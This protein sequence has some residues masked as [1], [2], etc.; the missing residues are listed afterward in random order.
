MNK[1]QLARILID[2]EN[3]NGGIP[4]Y[5]TVDNEELIFDI[6]KMP[7]LIVFG[8]NCQG[9]ISEIVN[10]LNKK[11]SRQFIVWLNNEEDLNEL[12]NDFCRRKSHHSMYYPPQVVIIPNISPFNNAE[13]KTK[14]MKILSEGASLNSYFICACTTDIIVDDFNSAFPIVMCESY[15]EKENIKIDHWFVFVGMLRKVNF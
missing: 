3:N 5:L 1:E 7:N 12:Y 15:E 2:S 11:L 8:Q 10:Q 9:T 4:V 14:L 13:Q 6:K